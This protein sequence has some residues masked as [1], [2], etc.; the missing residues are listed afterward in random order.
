MGAGWRRW[1]LLLALLARPDRARAR[2]GGDFRA[3]VHNRYGLDVAQQLER[4]DL[5]ED[6]SL[7][8]GEAGQPRFKGQPVLIVHG[9]TNKVSRFQVSRRSREVSTK[10]V[11][12]GY[13]SPESF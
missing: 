7:G 6:A 3:F 11:G 12:T 10:E 2:F 4:L 1:L 5:G 8:G 13:K 9:I